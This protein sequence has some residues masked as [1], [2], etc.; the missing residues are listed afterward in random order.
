MF[1][2]EQCKPI[3]PLVVTVI[4]TGKRG[5]KPGAKGLKEPKGRDPRPRD[6]KHPRRTMIT[7]YNIFCSRNRAEVRL[8]NPGVVARELERLMGS[9]WAKLTPEQKAPYDREAAL[10][11]E[12][13]Q[14]NQAEAAA[15]IQAGGFTNGTGYV[16]DWVGLDGGLGI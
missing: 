2:D 5:P 1:P 8:A 12:V 6:P 7:S 14:R 13:T 11:N 9:E 3:L 4:P 16:W 10:Q 15:A